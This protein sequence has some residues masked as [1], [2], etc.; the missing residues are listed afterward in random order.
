VPNFNEYINGEKIFLLS[1]VLSEEHN[2]IKL[3]NMI[4]RNDED[5]LADI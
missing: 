4:E 1:P 3:K 5:A 2:Q